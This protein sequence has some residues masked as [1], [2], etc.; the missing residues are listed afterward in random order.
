MLTNPRFW[1]GL[2]VTAGFLGLLFLRVDFGDMADALSGANYAYLAPGIAVYFVS[3]Y[4][5]SL[6]WQFLLRPFAQTRA[7]RLYPVVLVGY[8]ANNLLPMRVGE[9][10]RSYYLSV[11]EPVRG[12]TG[13]ATVIVERV[14]DGLT[15]LLLLVLGALFLPLSGLTDRVSEAVNLPAWAVAAAVPTPFIGV[16][17]LMVLAALR[18]GP[19][20]AASGWLAGRFPHR[21]QAVA[22]GLAERFILGFE[23]LHRPGRL[24]AV[25]ALSLPVWLTEGAMYY[26]IAL[27]FGLDEHFGSLWLLAMATLVVVSMSNLATSIPSSQGS[28]GPFEFFAALS[29]VFL[30]VGSGLASAYAIVLHL[31]LLLPVIAAGLIHLAARSVSLGQLTSGRADKTVGERS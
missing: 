11:R 20:L 30:G 15:L 7:A 2:A 23:G 5:R 8:M 16:L 31:A 14:F 3:L 22:E 12:S 17:S 21:F 13:L 25:F 10:V 4:F 24:A 9:L 26:I 6:R 29:L 18:P 1:T 19:F 27:G 28:V